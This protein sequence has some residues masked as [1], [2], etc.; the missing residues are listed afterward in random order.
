MASCPGRA[1]RHGRFCNTSK[2]LDLD[3]QR[4]A[5][6]IGNP[7]VF[8]HSPRRAETPAE[9]VSN[10]SDVSGRTEPEQ[11]AWLSTHLAWRWVAGP[12]VN[13]ASEVA[14]SNGGCCKANA[15]PLGTGIRP[16]RWIIS[17]LS[18]GNN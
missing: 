2:C 8:K 13:A 9:S 17:L 4:S 11:L 7:K 14:H 10:L 1:K 18:I 3:S 5:L 6:E 15:F 12:A 16:K